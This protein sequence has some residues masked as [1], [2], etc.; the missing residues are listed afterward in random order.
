M[1]VNVIKYSI[2]AVCFLFL[3]FVEIKTGINAFT[4]PFFFALVYLKQNVIITAPLLLISSIFLT[5]NPWN[6]LY[7]A[8]PVVVA[9][10]ALFVHYKTGKPLKP[11]FILLYDFL[12]YIPFVVLTASGLIPLVKGL[13]SL[14]IS[15]PLMF[16]YVLVLGCII[17][18]KL[19]FSLARVEKF[20]FLSCVFVFSL[21]VSYLD[22]FFFET[23]AFFGVLILGFAPITGLLGAVELGVFIGLGGVLKSP[24]NFAIMSCYGA[25]CALMPKKHGY[26]GGIIGVIITFALMLVKVLEINYLALTAPVLAVIINL[27]IPVKIKDKIIKRF[28][29]EPIGTRA[30]VNK[31]RQDLKEQLARLS[32]SLNEIALSISEEEVKTELNSLEL[33]TEVSSRVCLSCARY[34]HCKKCLGGAGTEI[35][36]QELMSSAIALGKASIL[37][38]SPFLSSRCLNLTGVIVKANEV[39]LEKKESIKKEGQEIE[40]KRLLKEQVEGLGSVLNEVA[41]NVGTPLIYDLS[42]ENRL[43]EEFN[44]KGIFVSDIIIYADGKVSLSLLEGDCEKPEVQEIV[45]KIMGTPM[46][47]YD[48]KPS[49]NGRVSK[50]YC[51]KPKYKIAY[52]ER[53]ASASFEGSGDREA[54]VRLNANKVML[55]LSDG[56]GHGKSASLNS[57]CALSLIT[58]LYQ[59]GFDHLTVLKSVQTLLKVRNKEEF[60]AIDI[61]VIDTDTG[62]VDIIK[63]GAREGYIITPDGLEVIECG[64]LPLGIVEG[65][66][67]ITERRL[68]TARDFILLL[69]DGII[70]GL[71]KQRLEELLSSIYT[72]NPDEV[73]TVVMDNVLKLAPRERDDCSMICARLF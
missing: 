47:A 15:F 72:Y 11:A 13:A 20:A 52:G 27:A 17:N 12:S 22:V 31:N 28:N 55:C 62:E 70:D 65:A 35:V 49:I 34:Q 37:D 48:T 54:V 23:Y 59:A 44:Y 16:V 7:F 43:K 19:R 50:F 42:K 9:L 46:W 30:L 58:S 21:G 57:G 14:F 51:R 8:V 10:V 66:V 18:K 67:P 53:V 24:L 63:Q 26:F 56:M 69:S 36:I 4:V 1:K 25:L 6:I 39:L 45:S 33:A 71:G 38:A 40:N 32:G 68:L 29:F 2:Y 60:N 61:A 41:L 73:C 3:R 5:F 64:S